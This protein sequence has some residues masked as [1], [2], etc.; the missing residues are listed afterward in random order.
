MPHN[1]SLQ[2]RTAWWV[3]FCCCAAIAVPCGVFFAHTFHAGAT[4]I[5]QTDI[6]QALAEYDTAIT[7][8]FDAMNKN[9]AG[10]ASR[11]DGLGPREAA[12]VETIAEDHQWLHK[13]FAESGHIHGIR[14]GAKL[15]RIVE[16]G[17][18][19]FDFQVS[20]THQYTA[21]DDSKGE[22]ALKVATYF[23][24]VTAIR[25]GG[26]FLFQPAVYSDFPMD[27]DPLQ[28]HGPSLAQ[29]GVQPAPPAS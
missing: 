2:G 20:I 4:Q 24:D 16:V 15:V 22:D 13:Q 23:F 18:K 25:T 14:G 27:H 26:G 5:S 11:T 28:G 21:T 29:M 3:A 8:V 9:A 17:V 6:D 7:T 12:N 19:S 10:V 1:A